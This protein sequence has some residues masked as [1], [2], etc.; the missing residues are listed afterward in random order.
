[1]TTVL[2]SHVTVDDSAFYRSHRRWPKGRGGWLFCDYAV[3]GQN[4]YLSHVVNFNGTYG[5]AKRA[6]KAHFAALGIH[7]IVVCP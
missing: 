2:P 6:A 1:M 5:E 4:D 3:W 7:T